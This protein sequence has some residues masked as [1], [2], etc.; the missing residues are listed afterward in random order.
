MKASGPV[1]IFSCSCFTLVAFYRNVA[2]LYGF[3]FHCRLDVIFLCL[4]VGKEQICVPIVVAFISCLR[5]VIK[6]LHQS[7]APSIASQL[8]QCAPQPR[9]KALLLNLQKPV[10]LLLT[11]SSLSSL[12]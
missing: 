3:R 12:A 5:L 8:V 6:V 1:I 2:F 4:N 9:S 10:F 7:I 11:L